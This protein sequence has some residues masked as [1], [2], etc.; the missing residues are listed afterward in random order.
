[1]TEPVTIEQDFNPT[2]VR[3]LM[4]LMSKCQRAMM[5]HLPNNPTYQEAETNLRTALTEYW[6]EAGELLLR[7]QDNGLLWHG[8]VVLEEPNRDDSMGWILFKD[9]IIAVKILPGADEEVMRFLRAI[10]KARTLPEDAEDD[11]RTLLWA[12]DF[13]TIK[14]DY[15][16]IGVGMERT[17]RLERSECFAVSPTPLAVHREVAL[18]LEGLDLEGVEGI[19]KDI[20]GM[21]DFDSSLYFLD[22][23]EIQYLGSE[24]ERE[25]SQNMRRNV[26][27]MLFDAMELDENDVERAEIVTVLD[28]FF[29]YLLGAGDFWSVAYIIREAR[30]LADRFGAEHRIRLASFAADLSEPDTL[31]HV[32]QTLADCEDMPSEEDLREIFGQLQPQAIET[33]LAWLPRITHEHTKRILDRATE[34]L[35]AAHPEAVNEALA[36]EDRTVL[37]GALVLMHRLNIKTADSELEKLTSHVDVDVRQALVDAL[38]TVG[39]SGALRQL[40]QLLQDTE[41]G[42][43]IRAVERLSAQRHNGALSQIEAAVLGKGIR[44]ADL[45]EKR[46]FFHAYGRLSGNT[47]VAQLRKLL[48]TSLFRRRVDAATR[49]CAAMALG[50]IGSPEARA[51]LKESENDKEPLVRVAVHEAL[52]GATA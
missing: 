41:R 18:D 13:H 25:Y 9:G 34:Q 22:A 6:R 32:L 17:R 8:H 44:L 36:S 12:E 37:V 39:T 38:A 4:R 26:L 49:A 2:P 43:R 3:E 30:T 28:E 42:V 51:T 47:A 24:I 19:A 29:R 23:D 1:M 5:L 35:A 7:V 33:A 46:A 11:A 40:E 10:H 48:V 16:V 52:K 14:L 20:I 27:S 21:D 45:T 31:N 50:E 15:V